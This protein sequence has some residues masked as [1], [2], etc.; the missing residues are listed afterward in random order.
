MRPFYEVRGVP[1]HS[2]I[3]VN[4]EDEALGFPT[5]DIRLEHCGSCGFVSNM[6]FDASLQDYHPGYEDQ[7]SFSPTFNSFAGRLAQRLIEKYDVRGK[8]VV[9]I[10]CGKGDFL[11]LMC[12]AGDNRGVGIDPTCIKERMKTPAIDR[13]EIIQDYYSEKYSDRTG[14]MMMCRHT[15]EHIHGTKDFVSTI[16]RGIG[17]KHD[18]IVFFEIPCVVVVLEDRVFWD[19]YYEHCT[20]FSPG[21]LGRMFRA[22]GF[23]VID[24]WR[25]YDDQ[26]LMIEARPVAE[27]STKIHPLEESLE[28]M[29]ALVERFESTVQQEIQG[30]RDRITQ[31]NRSEKKPVVWGSG[32]KCVAF[33]TTLGMRDEIGAVVDINPHRHGKFIPGAGKQVVGP[34]Y[35]KEYQPDTIIVMNPVYKDEIKKMIAEL[36]V[37]ANVITV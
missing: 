3:M 8:S 17:D 11:A 20:Y 9:E 28:D 30:W 18:T 33:L 21:S 26:Y 24:I 16:R 25:D 27:T 6:A 23:E 35:L 10:G 22:C 14:D 31:L 29:A 4:S 12:E 36:G 34:E 1:V 15:L 2:C 13:I 37:D 7:Q 32:S 19:V 5:G